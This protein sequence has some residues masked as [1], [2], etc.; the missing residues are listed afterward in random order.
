MK[1]FVPGS[2][3]DATRFPWV[4]FWKIQK[5]L[6]GVLK[7]AGIFEDAL[8]GFNGPGS[9]LFCFRETR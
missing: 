1:W 8:A 4:S 9:F 3:R 6:K 5:Q 2:P 7:R